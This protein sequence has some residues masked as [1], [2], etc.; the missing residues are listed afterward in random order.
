MELKGS[1]HGGSVNNGAWC[2]PCENYVISRVADDE[3][4]NLK[5]TPIP[6]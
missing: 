6:L 1:C 4:Q 3:A 5:Y 2:P